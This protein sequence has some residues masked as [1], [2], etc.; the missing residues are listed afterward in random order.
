MT[1]F[2]DLPPEI[3]CE[4]YRLV[5]GRPRIFTWLC[6]T[7]G[8]V[9][10]CPKFGDFTSPSRGRCPASLLRVCKVLSQEVEHIFYDCME[11]VTLTKITYKGC[12]NRHPLERNMILGA[13]ALSQIRH[14]TVQPSI[15]SRSKYGSAKSVRDIRRLLNRCTS[16]K[17][18]DF[19]VYFQKEPVQ[20]WPSTL[21][22][23]CLRQFPGQMIPITVM[24][25]RG[26]KVGEDDIPNIWPYL[27]WQEIEGMLLLMH[28]RVAYLYFQSQ[29]VR[30]VTSL[31]SLRPRAAFIVT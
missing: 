22:Q 4:I 23:L 11:L 14:L 21:H 16:L 30:G 15:A 19:H 26:A 31:E 8:T 3:R 9:V 5:I 29:N 7:P 2:L 17:Y 24:K 1:T 27:E 6:S 18:L 10:R 25:R 20:S 13:R 28:M 12:R